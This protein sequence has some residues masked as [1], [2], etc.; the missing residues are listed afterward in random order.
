MEALSSH[1][2]VNAKSRNGSWGLRVSRSKTAG[3]FCEVALWIEAPVIK[4][5]LSHERQIVA[6]HY[7]IVGAMPQD[8][9]DFVTGVAFDLID[10]FRGVIC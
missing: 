5:Q 3:F 6:M 9:F 4:L 10:F 1:K 2:S 7:F 8:V